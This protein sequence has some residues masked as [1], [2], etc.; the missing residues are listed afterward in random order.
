MANDLLIEPQNTGDIEAAVQEA[1]EAATAA[2]RERL[3]QIVRNFP[4]WLGEQAKRELLEAMM[5]NP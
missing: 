4:H 2:E 1:W 5:K 3:A